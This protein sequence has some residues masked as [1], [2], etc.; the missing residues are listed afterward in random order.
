MQ[1]GPGYGHP[2]PNPPQPYP[3]PPQ[4]PGFGGPPPRKNRVPL[5]VG[6]IV[7][8]AVLGIAAVL[9]FTLSGGDSG[10]D[11]GDSSAGT[12]VESTTTAAPPSGVT[13]EITGTAPAPLTVVYAGSGGEDIERRVSTLPWSVT[14]DPPPDLLS[15]FALSTSIE[16]EPVITLTVKRGTEVLRTC[17]GGAP[18][19]TD[20]PS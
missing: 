5:V 4:P 17:E 10:G 16:A 14:V 15:I 20:I 2:V 11:K 6:A 7:A 8:V 1:P 13:Y 9:V 12:K 19:I 3:F 18:C